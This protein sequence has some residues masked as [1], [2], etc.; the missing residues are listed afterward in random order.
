MKL[1]D[2][3]TLGILGKGAFGEVTLVKHYQTGMLYAVKKI[4]KD[5]IRG[6]KHI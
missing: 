5:R 3:E 2:F 4:A 6:E 1:Q